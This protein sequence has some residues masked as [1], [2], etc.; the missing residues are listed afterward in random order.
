MISIGELAAKGKGLFAAKAAEAK[1]NSAL[2]P[3]VLPAGT[4]VA[5]SQISDAGAAGRTLLQKATLAEIQA[6]VSGVGVVVGFDALLSI[7]SPTAG[8]RFRVVAPVIPGGV[9][10]TQWI[11]DGSLWRLDGTQDLL[12]DFTP[13]VGVTGTAEQFLKSWLL[14]AGL[15]A[16]LRYVSIYTVFAKSGTTD[17]VT[18]SR[19]RVGSA[20][21][22][23]DTTVGASAGFTA[24]NRQFP[25][26]FQAEFPAATTWRQI[27]SGTNGRAVGVATT[28]PY[29][30]NVT[31]PSTAGALYAS[32]TMQMAGTT[33][34]PTV[35]RA[36]ISGG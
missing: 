13:A 30:S 9:P 10:H 25:L 6:L 17:A 24:A 7:S 26:D 18:L 1:A 28:V 23:S 2:Q 15:L 3:G 29:P 33:D 36:I 8:M 22:A 16:S 34:V 35:A 12:V 11:H 27:G 4:T 5:A 20:G 19:L 14:P 21:S 32:L 31:I